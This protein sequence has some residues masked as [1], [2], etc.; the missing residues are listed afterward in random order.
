MDDL[1][2]PCEM[3]VLCLDTG[4]F[5]IF[6]TFVIYALGVVLQDGDTWPLPYR[7]VLESP[8]QKVET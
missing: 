4:F 2:R 5:V 6:Q 7:F 3:L 8:K 1:F